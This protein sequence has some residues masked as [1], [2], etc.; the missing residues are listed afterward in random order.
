MSAFYDII[1]IRNPAVKELFRLRV[2]RRKVREQHGHLAIVRGRQLIQSIGEHF[3]FKAVY[4]YESRDAFSSYNADRVV[5]VER[6]I[7]KHVL[8]GPAKEEQ[9]KRLDKDDFVVGTIEQPKPVVQFDPSPQWIL[10]VDGIKHPENMGLLLTSAVALKFDGVV[11]SN[12]CVDPFSYKVIEASQGVAWSMP[13]QY[14]TPAELLELCKRNSLSACAATLDGTP[15]DELPRLDA[16]RRGF[17]LI[18]GNEANGVRPELL[19]RCRRVTLPMSE[20]VESLNA[21]VAGGILMHAL[22]CT[23][24]RTPI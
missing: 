12:D 14:A 18:V 15:L 16:Q 5:R 11:F 19:D 23:W 22:A 10:A 2:G 17:C 13:Y 9:A 24:G 21:G 7:L 3:K 4:T 1:S 20:L 8:F 6:S